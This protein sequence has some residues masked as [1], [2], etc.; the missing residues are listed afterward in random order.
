MVGKLKVTVDGSKLNTKERREK[1]QLV[2]DEM[3]LVYNSDVFR[4]IFLTLLDQRD[5]QKGELSD[6]R[7]HTPDEIYRYFMNGV[8]VLSPE[9][10][11]E[12][13]F[14]VDDYYTFKKVIG[15]TYPNDKY[16]Y[17][18]TKYLDRRSSKLVG[19]NFTHEYGHK[20]GF[21]HD[22]R[23]TKRRE[24]S[25][26]Y[27]LNIAYERAWDVIFGDI[28]ERDK[29]LVCKRRWIFFKKCWWENSAVGGKQLRLI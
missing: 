11:Y 24:D 25:L 5:Y 7:Y 18:N 8:E 21:K 12:V 26:S 23:R 16:V 2:A 15:H 1:A 20:K 28:S 9:L 3:R 6:W 10:D 29:V 14:F 4:G 27:L 13:D 17:S 22:F 19:S